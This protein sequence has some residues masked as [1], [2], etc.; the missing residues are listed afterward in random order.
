MCVALIVI[1]GFDAVELSKIKSSPSHV[2]FD[3]AVIALVPVPVRIELSARLV[4]PVPPS[5][6][7]KVPVIDEAPRSTANSVDSITKPHWILNQ[8]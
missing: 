2:R 7:A 6:T 4:A 5:P 1:N 8:C 3:S